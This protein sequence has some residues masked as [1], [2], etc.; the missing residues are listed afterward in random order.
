LLTVFAVL[1]ERL[2]LEA[3]LGAFLAGA[4]VNLV[5]RDQAMTHPEFRR[6]L[7]AVGYGVF[8]PVFFVATGVRFDLNGLFANATN[9]AR[10]PI[11]LAA[12]LV[13][14][15]LPAL[16]YRSI[17]TGTQTAAAGLLQATS[18][19]FLVAAG[20]IGVQLDLLRPAVY[21]ALVAAGV[22]SVMLFPLTALTL[23]RS[24]REGPRDVLQ[25]AR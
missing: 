1:A 20:Q 17:T 12:L 13:A 9:I 22:L 14:R 8:V 10:V 4:I 21:A 5:D 19:S 24:A 15:G 7:E 23:L 18:L 6:K 25:A 3:I 11:F 2:G 16:V